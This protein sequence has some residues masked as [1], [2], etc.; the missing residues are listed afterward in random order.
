VRFSLTPEEAW[1][2]AEAIARHFRKHGASIQVERAAWPDVPY[3]TTLAMVQRGKTILVEAQGTLS[4]GP[5]LQDL[6]KWLSQHRKYA[7]FFVAIAAEGSIPVGVFGE[8]QRDGVGLLIV[9]DDRMVRTDRPARNP[10]LVV[11][12]E[13]TLAYGDC[14]KD[15]LAAVN[16]FNNVDRKDGLR[17]MCEVVERETDRLLRH[18]AKKAIV[19]LPTASIDQKDWSEQI[20]SLASTALHGGKAPTVNNNLKHDLHSFRGARNLVD[21]KVKSKRD[22][23]K[24]Q[25]QFAER[26]MQG[27]RLVAELV[28]LRRKLK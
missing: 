12:P 20:D 19:T 6:S 28:A 7:E 2:I 13:P 1:P 23:K 11:T 9:D 17:D 21:H 18:A 24:R 15:V 10:A 26:M 27:P 8:L 5:S 16:K 25:T 22:D 4:Y 14:K 3:R